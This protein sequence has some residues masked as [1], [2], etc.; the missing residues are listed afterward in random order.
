[1]EEDSYIMAPDLLVEFLKSD[2]RSLKTA[3]YLVPDEDLRI[4][5]DNAKTCRI[6]NGILGMLR[7]QA[8]Q[9][10]REERLK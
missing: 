10:M 8:R 1:M 2:N 9:T 6:K 5:I 3:D 7:L 4:I